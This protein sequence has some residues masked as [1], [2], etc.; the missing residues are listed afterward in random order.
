MAR[1]R[2]D[3]DVVYVERGSSLAPF[4]W[5]LGIGAVAAL[6]LAPMSGQELR[7]ELG[8]RGRRLGRMAG[9]KAEELEEMVSDG[10]ARVKG[11]VE[12]GVDE[13]RRAV[14][15]GRDYAR[16]VAD[17]GRSAAVTARDELEKRLAEARAARRGARPNG[18][19]EPVA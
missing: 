1:D 6:L 5:G 9:E 15:E 4:L 3:E 12:E 18:E 13:A 2:D 19:E 8:R 17:A 10:F 7:D 16:D 14:R 11:R